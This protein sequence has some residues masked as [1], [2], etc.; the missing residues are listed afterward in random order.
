MYA[1]DE[2][3]A[4]ITQFLPIQLASC[5]SLGFSHLQVY[6]SAVRL[7]SCV[8]VYLPDGETAGRVRLG[9]AMQSFLFYTSHLLSEGTDVI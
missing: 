4:Y 1:E 7:P 6:S 2:T 8:F 9:S 5:I 3:V